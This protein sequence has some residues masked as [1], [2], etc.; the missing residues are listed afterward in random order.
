MSIDFRPITGVWEITMGCNM[1]CKHCGSS[2]ENQLSG[3]LTTDE[4]LNLCDDLAK[5][6]FQW[7]TLS[8]GEPT[9]RKDWDIIAKRLNDNGII[10]NMITNGWLMDEEIAKRAKSAGINTVA[11]SLDGLEKTHDFIRREGSFKRI[12]NAIDILVENGVNCSIITTVNKMNLGELE[13]MHSI[14][15]GKG[16]YGWQFQLG[17]PMGN[18]AKNS[19][20]VSQPHHMDDVI[21]FAYNAMQKSDIDIQLADC[22]G[23]FNKKEIAVR[24]KSDS[25]DR[26]DWNG[27]GAGKYVMGVLHN[28]DI[29][30]CT[31]IRDRNFI[32]G[33][34]KETPILELWNNPEKFSWNR[35]IT[36]DMLQGTCKK[37]QYGNRCHGGCGNTR[38][39]MEGTIYGQNRYCSYNLAVQK[40]EKQFE[41]LNDIDELMKKAN[42]FAPLNQ[43]QL[44]GILLERVLSIDPEN[45]EALSLYGYTS[46]MLENYNDA[47]QANKKLLSKD[48]SNVYANKGY[49]LSIARL[50]MVDEGISYLKKA[51]DLSNG[52][53][54]D[55]YYDLAVVYYENGR[56]VEA[57]KSL[58]EGFKLSEE[59]K[60][61]NQAFYNIIKA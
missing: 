39:T 25:T 11:I 14:L 2:C 15:S 58:E 41:G 5:L 10:P 56:L 30:G 7:L 38:L 9:T 34:I 47:A 42:K 19:D 43:H 18:M 22:M 60:N 1:R 23:Y 61:N 51:I 36:K 20:L 21:N 59:F 3:E 46:F 54:L 35:N 4:A 17:L 12:M 57:I 16:I 6:G 28:G 8:G 40:A 52:T 37:C 29:V 13:E 44:T 55:P 26:Y 49:G 53:Y 33:N 31:S 50:G 48:S 24:N 27:C 32:E 45:E